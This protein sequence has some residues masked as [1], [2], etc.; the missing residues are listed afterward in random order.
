MNWGE[1]LQAVRL[2]VDRYRERRPNTTSTQRV[3]QLEQELVASCVQYDADVQGLLTVIEEMRQVQ[4]TSHE[5]AAVSIAPGVPAPRLD[6]QRI[7][8]VGDE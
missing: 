1:L 7:L 8:V 6:G 5:Q 2:T 4:R 3:V